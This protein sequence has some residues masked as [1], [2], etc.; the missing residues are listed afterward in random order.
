MELQWDH[1]KETRGYK[2]DPENGY[3]NEYA[4]LFESKNGHRQRNNNAYKIKTL[5]DRKV[6]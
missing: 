3:Y 6:K 1:T 4:K 5:E 2:P